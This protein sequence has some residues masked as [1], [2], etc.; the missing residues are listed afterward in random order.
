MRIEDKNRNRRV[1]RC[2]H[3]GFGIKKSGEIFKK[4]PNPDCGLE[5]LPVFRGEGKN[6]M[7]RSY[8]IPPVASQ[9][10]PRGIILIGYPIK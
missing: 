10:I 4:C 8:G 9:E 3:C 1:L 6:R 7:L 5:I 2:P